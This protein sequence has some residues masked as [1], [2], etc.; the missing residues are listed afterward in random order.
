M[1]FWKTSRFNKWH[2]RLIIK[3]RFTNYIIRTCKVATMLN[4]HMVKLL[5]LMEESNSKLPNV[6]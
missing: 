3:S 1:F 6:I 4:E 2:V 5:S